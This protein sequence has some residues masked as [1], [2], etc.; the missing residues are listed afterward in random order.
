MWRALF[1]RRKS[2]ITAAA[3]ELGKLGAATRRE[4][5]RAKV[6]ETAI[7][8]QRDLAAKGIEVP[9]RSRLI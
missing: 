1:P 9:A 7:Q 4:R 3:S 8:M 2:T 5:E 6:H